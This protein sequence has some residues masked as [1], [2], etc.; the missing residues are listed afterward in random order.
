M[1]IPGLGCRFAFLD[2]WNHVDYA[3][4]RPRAPKSRTPQIANIA[5][6]GSGTTTT[7]T[8]ELSI[9]PMLEFMPMPTLALLILEAKLPPLNVLRSR[10][11]LETS[12]V[13]TSIVLAVVSTSMA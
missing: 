4:F 6:E 12:F 8:W 11:P 7:P 5:D 1:A 10:I 2:P 3:R 9:Q 13:K